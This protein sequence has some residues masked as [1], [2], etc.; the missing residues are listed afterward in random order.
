MPAQYQKRNARLTNYL[1][2]D[3]KSAGK[4]DSLLVVFAVFFSSSPL[5]QDLSFFFD[6]MKIAQP[7]V[8]LANG[9]EF[10]YLSVQESLIR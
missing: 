10:P 1:F 3:L 2:R 5:R 6:M 4:R 8:V 9:L 7:V